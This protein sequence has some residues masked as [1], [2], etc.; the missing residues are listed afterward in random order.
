MQNKATANPVSREPSQTPGGYFRW[1]PDMSRGRRSLVLV[2]AGLL[3]HTAI[4]E[5]VLARGKYE[6]ADLRALERIF[7]N[8][9]DDVRPS[10]TAIRTFV[11]PGG[12][13][14]RGPLRPYSQGSGFIVD[15]KGFV[16]T[17]YH[18]VEGSD[19]VRVILHNGESLDA[20]VVATDRRRDLAVLNVDRDNLKP[21]RFGD[22]ENLKPN[23]WTFACGN[24]FGFANDNGN[25]SVAWG[26]VTALGRDMTAALVEDSQVEY[27]GN[28]IETSSAINPG[29]SGG[30]LF[31]IDGSVIGIVTAI[32][33]SSGV[34]EGAGF[35]IPTNN[36]TLRILR[37]LQDG[38]PM[39][40]GFLGVEI[41]PVPESIWQTV[42]VAKSVSGALITNIAPIDG[43]AARA[44][45]QVE[46]I[47][48]YVDGKPVNGSD[49]LVRLIQYKP[50]GA[51]V[52]VTYMRKGVT[53]KT[54][55]TLG[56]REILMAR[57]DAE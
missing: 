35:A 46:D 18:V 55:V 19:L 22:A 34:N 25:T 51:K 31:N 42:S 50:V 39:R 30:P 15:E 29:N 4:A 28:L 20:E 49:E 3:T 53:R 16:A 11:I 32:E 33:T 40:Y 23:M 13:R 47:V 37:T 44:G 41:R 2:L 45:L 8:L 7:V 48:L 57:T 38:K 27:Y 56:D 43:P 9:A 52:E 1:A 36:D 10:V 6:L 21:V 24:P 12:R 54:N 26:T 17:N 14:A 5:P